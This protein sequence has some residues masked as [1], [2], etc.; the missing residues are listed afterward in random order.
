MKYTFTISALSVLFCFSCIKAKKNI[1]DYYPKVETVSA[2]IT[3]NGDI[4]VEGS[5]DLSG[6]DTV[7][8]V[9]FC[10]DTIPEPILSKNQREFNLPTSK[11]FSVQYNNVDAKMSFDRKKT[12]YFRTWAANKYGYGYG[13]TINLA[14]IKG[15]P[16]DPPCSLSLGNLDFGNGITSNTFT[17]GGPY[18]NNDWM[19]IVSFNDGINSGNL[20]FRFGS[21]PVTRTFTIT[22]TYPPQPGYTKVNLAGNNLGTH[23]LAGTLVYVKETSD[24][25]FEISICNAPWLTPPNF[26]TTANLNTRFAA[27]Y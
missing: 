25:T 8:A 13:N 26:N 16:V 7:I 19:T 22:T 3:S 21:K 11:S 23:L 4:I 10:V 14:N 6:K 9:G 17:V 24:T 15:T 18:A 20:T 27:K 1:N 2:S 5:V 12:Y